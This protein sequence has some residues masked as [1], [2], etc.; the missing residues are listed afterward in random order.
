MGHSHAKLH[1]IDITCYLVQV[2]Q[3]AAADVPPPDELK[4]GGDTASQRKATFM[5]LA[6]C[7]A[8]GLDVQGIATLYKAAKPFMQVSFSDLHSPTSQTDSTHLRLT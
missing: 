2:T 6:L 5:E 4:E 8:A 1:S 7:L 3:D